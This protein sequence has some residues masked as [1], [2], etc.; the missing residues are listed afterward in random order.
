MFGN[1]EAGLGQHMGFASSQ[2]A[3]HGSAGDL[4]NGLRCGTPSCLLL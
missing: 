3:S 4:A 2:G 1:G